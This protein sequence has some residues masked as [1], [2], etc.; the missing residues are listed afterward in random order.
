MDMANCNRYVGFIVAAALFLCG[1]SARATMLSLTFTDPVGDN[2]GLVDVTRLNLVFSNTTGDY[3]VLVTASPE[4]PFLGNFRIN[5][6]LFNPDTG[7]TALLPSYFRDTV[8]DYY[9]Q[10]PTTTLTWSGSNPSLGYWKFGDRVATTHLPFGNPDFATAFR[11]A[12]S[13]LPVQPWGVAEDIIAEGGYTTIVPEPGVCG[14]LV[15]GIWLFA[16]RTG[17]WRASWAP[18]PR[19]Y[20]IF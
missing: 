19:P 15:L 1:S 18:R 2:T 16:G 11:T 12:V 3:T 7:S 9:L 8:H 14:V 5:I 10:I 20:R 13:D 6:N 17:R 4:H